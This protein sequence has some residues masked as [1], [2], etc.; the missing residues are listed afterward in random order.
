VL[1]A[2]LVLAGGAAGGVERRDRIA[3]ARD[4]D[5]FLV[6]PDG[7]SVARVTRGPE[8]DGAPALSPD[9]ER[10]AFVRG[11]EIWVVRW[12][13]T[14]ARRLTQ[15][16]GRLDRDPA[17]SPDGRRLAWSSGADGS[18]D[19][20]TM[21]ADGSGKRLFV[22]D[23]GDDVEPSWSPSGTEVVFASTRLGA[24]D[25]WVAPAD[26][27]APARQLTGGT[28]AEREPAWG[29]AG[30][31]AFVG[32]GDG[33]AE[34]YGIQADGSGLA[35]LTEHAGA[36][37]SPAWSRDATRLAFSRDGVLAIV[38]AAGGAVRTFGPGEQP[39]WGA[40]PPPPPP[41]PKPKPPEPPEPAE[42]LP[43]LDQRAPRDLSI[44][45][46]R[47]RFLLGFTSATDNV[48]DGPL[49]IRG[50][51]PLPRGDMTAF[52]LIRR[53]DGSV[54]VV[55]DVGRIRYTWSASHSHFHLLR[56]QRFELRRAR[57]FAVV[58]RDRKTGFCLADHYGL[59]R[60]RVR[61]FSPPHFLGDCLKGE[62]DGLRVEQGTSPGYTDRYPA[63]FH[64]QNVDVTEL[65]SGVYVLVNRANEDGKLRERRLSNNAAS[66]RIRLRWP[67]GRRSAP[68]VDVLRLCEGSERCPARS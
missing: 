20:Y 3:F 17:W 68:N 22:G 11:A 57:D 34:L 15:N 58:S 12:D 24:H 59:A 53:V 41:P 33:N 39:S 55:Q 46:S 62:P 5:L 7:R 45:V 66:A 60:N 28:G 43:E 1:P 25:L 35:R 38:G 29:L 42:L 6:A 21:N 31:I 49:W 65:P 26:G 37:L 51:R 13:G 67:N 32:D 48:G 52:Q 8:R 64:G 44:Q 36:D 27:S 61:N 30:R 4:G 9:G 14:R 18:F 54:A 10:I 63:H 56:F 2:V 16:P 19:L 50:E 40:I 47:G 23:A